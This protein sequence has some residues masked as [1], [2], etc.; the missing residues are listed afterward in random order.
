MPVT[1][2]EVLAFWRAA[3]PDKLFEKDDAL[4]WA[5]GNPYTFRLR[6][7]TYMQVAMLVEEAAKLKTRTWACVAPNYEYGQSCVRWF[8][9]L[10]KRARPDAEF[11]AEKLPALADYDDAKLPVDVRARAYLHS[12]CSHCHIKWGG[13]NADFKL[14]ATLPLKDMGIVNVSGTAT[15]VIVASADPSLSLG[16]FA[17]A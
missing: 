1:P 9:E 10:L 2:A 15:I 6:P 13:G 12:N 4:V 3:G 8:K 17:I 14:L 16:S 7:S 5:K 11:V